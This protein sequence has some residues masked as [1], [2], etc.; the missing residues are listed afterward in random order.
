VR[1]VG[2]S[3]FLGPVMCDLSSE[4]NNNTSITIMNLWNDEVIVDGEYFIILL[5]EYT[6][7]TKKTLKAHLT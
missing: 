2:T 6:A 4:N 1:G 5:Y 7:G 3:S